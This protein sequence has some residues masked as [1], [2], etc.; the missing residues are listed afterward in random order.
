MLTLN[1]LVA[2]KAHSARLDLF[3]HRA[4]QFILFKPLQ[5]I[6][7]LALFCLGTRLLWCQLD[8]RLRLRSG[9]TLLLLL[10]VRCRRVLAGRALP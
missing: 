1:E 3:R 6:S 5:W 8:V 4:A 2:H 7:R 10:L 9:M